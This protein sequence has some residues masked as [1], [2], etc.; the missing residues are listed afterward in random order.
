MGEK[1]STVIKLKIGGM[2]C[3]HCVAAVTQA[4]LGVPGVQSADVSLQ[5]SIAIIH[6]ID[7]HP[8]QLIHAIE[9]EGF[10]AESF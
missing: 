8:V 6:G 4:L 9:D 2:S 7:L 1:T 10:S 3:A 5:Q